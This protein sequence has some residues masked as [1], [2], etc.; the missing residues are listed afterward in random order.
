MGVSWTEILGFVT[1]AA[2]VLLA[3]RQ[4]VWNW[5]VGIANNIFFI[6]LFWRAALYADAMLQIVYIAIAIFGWWNWARGG[7][8]NTE[9]PISRMTVRMA[10]FL[11]VVTAMAT[12]LLSTAL[13]RFTNSVVPIADGVTTALS[14]TAQYMLSRK[15]LENWWA[16]MTADLVYIGLYYYKS[17]YLT[18]ALYLLFFAMCIAGYRTWRMCWE[19]RMRC[20]PREAPAL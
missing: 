8:G 12:L 4:S 18:S 15:F 7:E 17:L 5:P 11:T 16:W 9:L 20:C 14:L 6:I 13:H 1:G 2:S 10:I 3:V 19:S